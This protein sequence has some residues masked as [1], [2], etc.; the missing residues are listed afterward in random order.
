VSGLLLALLLVQAVPQ[1]VGVVTGVVRGANGMPAPGIRVYAMTVRDATEAAVAGTALESIAQTDSSGRYRLEVAAGRYY[2]ASGSVGSPTYYPGTTNV[3]T[4]RVVSIAAGGLIEGIDFSSFVP[5]SQTRGGPA[6]IAPLPPGSTGVI[7]G[8]IRFQDGRPAAQMTVA[9]IPVAVFTG[10]AGGAPSIT[11]IRVVSA[12]SSITVS[13]GGQ[14]PVIRRMVNGF[15]IVQAV[16]DTTGRYRLE[17]IPPD[18]YYI[19]TGYADAPVF[20]PGTSDVLTARTFVTTPTTLLDTQD[21]T[22]PTQAMGVRVS[23]RV[24]AL[25]GVPAAGATVRILN[26]APVS[27]GLMSASFGLANRNLN[28]PVTVKDDGT[29]EVPLPPGDYT[30]EAMGM[31]VP[32]AARTLTVADQPVSGIDFSIPVA[33]LSG[34]ILFEDGSALPNP[35]VFTDVLVSTVDNPN[36]IASTVLPI[37]SNGTFARL[38]EAKEYR[39]FLRNLPDEY[40]IQSITSGTQ[41]LLKETLKVTSTE[42]ATIQVRVTKRTV[43]SPG[44]AKV[45]GSVLDSLTGLPSPA[46]RVTLCC[47]D[48]GPW[49]RFSTPLRSDGSFEFAGVPR[50]RYELGLQGATG[51]PRLFPVDSRVEVADSPATGLTIQ[52]TPQLVQVAATIVLENGSPLPLGITATVVFTGASGRVRVISRR[53]QDVSYFVAWVPAGERY[54][55]SVTDLPDGYIVKTISGSVDVPRAPQATPGVPVP[56]APPPPTPILITVAPSVPPPAR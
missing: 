7:Q 48:S 36:L 4:A 33:S 18:T 35:Q 14:N 12:A 25:G 6:A 50:G 5:A 1:N 45:S 9:A 55:V 11:S 15:N 43:T 16:T 28:L 54:N 22:L 26:R 34:R 46:E 41:D 27:R 38:L 23:G 52:T 10:T 56:P 24:T 3:A 30:V 49:E 39:F 31:G 17:N 53:N 42:P 51:Q 44:D 32:A 8:T 13:A 2:I 20:F 29:F 37:S 21:F 40:S 19:A 47:F